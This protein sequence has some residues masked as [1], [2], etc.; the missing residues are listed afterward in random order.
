MSLGFGYI[1]GHEAMIQGCVVDEIE[2]YTV[3]HDSHEFMQH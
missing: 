2:L 1:F 3:V